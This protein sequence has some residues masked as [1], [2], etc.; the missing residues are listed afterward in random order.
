[1]FSLAA[2]EVLHPCLSALLMFS[3]HVTGYHNETRDMGPSMVTGVLNE[4][5]VGGSGRAHVP[6]DPRLTSGLSCS[7][8][9]LPPED[10][11]S[12][13]LHPCR[14]CRPQLT[15]HKGMTITAYA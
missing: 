4:R 12:G 5:F 8:F 15:P 13:S 14:N 11:W 1:M 9:L 2:P 10:G 3:C 7:P 6:A